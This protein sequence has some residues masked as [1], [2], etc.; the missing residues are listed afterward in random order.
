[1]GGGEGGQEGE[2]MGRGGIATGTGGREGESGRGQ[3][4]GIDGEESNRDGKGVTI[5]RGQ[6]EEEMERGAMGKGGGGDG[7]LAMG[8][9]ERGK[10]VGMGKGK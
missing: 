3:R 9:G 10:E 6:C 8:R 4:A 2:G 5:W 7:K 1:M